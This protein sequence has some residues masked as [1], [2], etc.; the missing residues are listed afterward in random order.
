MWTQL[1]EPLIPY[2]FYNEFIGLAKEAQSTVR[3][4]AETPELSIGLKRITF[5]IRDLLRQLPPAHYRTLHFLIA[6]LYRYLVVT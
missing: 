4:A 2:R 3:G 1:P 5:K 6:H